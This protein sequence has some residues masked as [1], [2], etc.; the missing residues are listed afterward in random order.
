MVIQ[1]WYFNGLVNNK[2]IHASINRVGITKDSIDSAIVIGTQASIIAINRH[3]SVKIKENVSM[4]T[5]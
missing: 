2:M 5:K 1:L 3:R 4:F